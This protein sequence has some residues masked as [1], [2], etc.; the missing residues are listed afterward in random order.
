[1]A[2]IVGIAG[3]TG[4]STPKDYY[5]KDKEVYGLGKV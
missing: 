5:D 1:M 3:M 4:S 2:R